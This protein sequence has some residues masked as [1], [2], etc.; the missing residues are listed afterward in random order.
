MWYAPR[1]FIPACPRRFPSPLGFGTTIG[2]AIVKDF[3]KFQGNSLY[4]SPYGR[5]DMGIEFKSV[6]I[7]WLSLSALTDVI[8]ALTM[9]QYLRS[10]RTGF[11]STEDILTKL[12]RCPYLRRSHSHASM[13][14]LALLCSYYSDRRC[15][16]TLGYSRPN[17]LS[18]PCE[19]SVSPLSIILIKAVEFYSPITCKT[20]VTK[21]FLTDYA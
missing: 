16:F 18:Q 10:H 3:L 4:P 13:V 8:I 5:R 14:F 6:V 9:V 2:C 12:V 20:Q 1:L 11:S 19:S 7:V 21:L 17:N 15:H